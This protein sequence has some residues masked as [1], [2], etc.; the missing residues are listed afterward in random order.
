LVPRVCCF[1]WLVCHTS[2]VVIFVFAL[3][4]LGSLVR[5]R[6]WHIPTAFVYTPVAA[7]TQLRCH[8]LPYPASPTYAFVPTRTVPLA[9]RIAILR[10]YSSHV[11][12]SYPACPPSLLVHAL[13]YVPLLPHS[14]V[15]LLTPVSTQLPL[16]YTTHWAFPV[17]VGPW[18]AHVV[19]HTTHHSFI[20]TVLC[21]RLPP[22]PRHTSPLPRCTATPS[23][24]YTP[25][26]PTRL[27]LTF[28]F[29]YLYTFFLFAL[30]V[31]RWVVW[32]FLPQLH[33]SHLHLLS[34]APTISC[35]ATY[36]LTT[37]LC[38]HL[39]A[40]PLSLCPACLPLF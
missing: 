33:Y 25:P 37:L 29:C 31:A 15:W 39:P 17:L 2:W 24:Y 3:V 40:T 30:L 12:S 20:F 34:P 18:F 8:H 21:I 5:L 11:F 9:F 6:G 28:L 14:H 22:S 19:T 36:H 26:P 27:Y 13:H 23:M 16:V 38:T 4:A 10:T 1:G 7:C 32:P 35:P